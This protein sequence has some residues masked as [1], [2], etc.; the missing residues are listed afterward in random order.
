MALHEQNP[1]DEPSRPLVRRRTVNPIAPRWLV[2]MYIAWFGLL[3]LPTVFN[4]L[5]PERTWFGAANMYLPQWGWAL[6]ALLI[7]PL[8]IWKQ[9]RLLIA[10]VLLLS[11]VVFVLMGFE[12]HPAKSLPTGPGLRLRIM[13]YNVKGGRRNAAAIVGDINR[14]KP[15]V[16]LMQDQQGVLE[17]PVGTCLRNWHVEDDYQFVAA[18]RYP[19]T[20]LRTQLSDDA[21]DDHC[22]VSFQLLAHGRRI[23][24]YDVHL[25][26]PRFGLEALTHGHLGKMARDARRRLAQAS[27][28]QR[29]LRHERIGSLIAAGD[30]NSTNWALA[31]RRQLALGLRDSFTV[32]GRGFGY[33][34]GQYTPL[35]MPVMRI[36]HVLVGSR[37]RVLNVQVGNT[38]G[39]DHAPVIAD[40]FLPGASTT[41][42]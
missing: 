30:F 38:I 37:W 27:R 31:L 36:D 17:G 2:V 28:L 7:V 23:T 12:W 25:R 6:P 35:H 26:S 39:S 29:Y 1:A 33:T 22:C 11:W 32:A 8:T 5:G 41:A 19:I 40:L 18:S 24:V 21:P 42:K 10:S 15:D 20:P 34:Y 13:T 9:P 3:L 16:L 4:I 14:F